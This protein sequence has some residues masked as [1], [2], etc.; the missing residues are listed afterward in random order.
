MAATRKRLQNRLRACGT[1]VP[2]QSRR[3]SRHRSP[4]KHFAGTHTPL[5]TNPQ[6]RHTEPRGIPLP[7]AKCRTALLTRGVGAMSR[8][9]EHDTLSQRHRRETPSHTR[10]R[11][12]VRTLSSVYD[13]KTWC[14][15]TFLQSCLLNRSGGDQRPQVSVYGGHT[16]GWQRG[17]VLGVV[18]GE[19]WSPVKSAYVVSRPTR[20]HNGDTVT[21]FDFVPDSRVFSVEVEGKIQSLPAH[22]LSIEAA[23]E[24]P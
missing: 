7:P 17:V 20:T 2:R 21:D 13:Q 14:S 19:S 5:H 3:K 24:V 6:T 1:Q 4:R 22:L 16:L 11:R 10:S 23:D 15:G 18:P 12:N 8:N 9:T